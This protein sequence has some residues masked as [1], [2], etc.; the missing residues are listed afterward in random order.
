MKTRTWLFVICLV[1]CLTGC[2][3]KIDKFTAS[4][5]ELDINSAY[6]IYE[7][8]NESE[9]VEL[10]K[11]VER[12]MQD[13]LDKKD[14]N[15]AFV[16][17][18]AFSSKLD[19]LDALQRTAVEKYY[20][21]LVNGEINVDTFKNLKAACIIALGVDDSLEYDKKVENITNGEVN[22]FNDEIPDSDIIS[23]APK[24]DINSVD[25]KEASLEDI[26]NDA[27]E[28]IVRAEMNYVDQY[29]IVEGYL[30]LGSSPRYLSV[31]SDISLY[32]HDNEMQCDIVTDEY[33]D[34]LTKDYIETRIHRRIK[35][36]GK[37]NSLSDGTTNT[38]NTMDVY[39][40]EI[41]ENKSA[42]E[43]D[44][45]KYTADDLME[46]YHNDE[47][48]TVKKLLG[49]YIEVSGTIDY[50]K[51]DSFVIHNPYE[52]TELGGI[53]SCKYMNDDIKRT[54]ANMNP[55]DRVTVRGRISNI[56]HVIH[57]IYEVDIMEIE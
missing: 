1:L 56:Q 42:A 32:D 4:M 10:N 24:F 44:F 41:D 11:V 17:Y 9:K 49:E 22:D 12:K 26:L 28:N 7:T 50:I 45:V 19:T 33:D 21:E 54:V 25:W 27:S 47:K 36:W 53:I 43:V 2:G 39:K 20:Q 16:L 52:T 51:S 40:F 57:I 6:K 34:I 18:S 14:M 48:G 37:I 46:L 23:D 30:G 13:A 5:D 3:S 8:A 29:V 35:V 31:E 55:G 15:S 38:Y